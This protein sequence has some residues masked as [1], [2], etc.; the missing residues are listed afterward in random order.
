M[1]YNNNTTELSKALGKVSGLSPVKLDNTI[2]GYTGTLGMMVAQ[3]PDMYFEDERNLPSKPVTER[4]MVRDFFLN[5][6]NMNRT[7]EEFYEMVNT[8]QQQHAGYGKKGHPTPAVKAVNKAL[9][10]V[11]KQQKEIQEITNAKNI[12]PDRK[13]QMIDKKREIIKMI[14]KK[15]LQRYGSKF[16]V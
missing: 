11:S 16:G 6:M 10:D 5:D 3:I 1:R 2:R 9:R 12:S 7:S 13:R 8:A 15:T 4:V 14:E